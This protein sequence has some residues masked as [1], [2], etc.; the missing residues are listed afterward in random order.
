MKLFFNAGCGKCVLLQKS[1][2]GTVLIAALDKEE[3]V[4]AINLAESG[5]WSQGHYFKDIALAT[6]KFNEMR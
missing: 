5:S 1:E 2:K 6:K 4:V 3:F